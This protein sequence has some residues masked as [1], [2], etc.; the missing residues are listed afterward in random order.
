MA[1]TL[2]EGQ[3]HA[4]L[5]RFIAT[6]NLP[7]AYRKGKLVTPVML[8]K[9]SHDFI[10]EFI[11]SIEYGGKTTSAFWSTE[12]NEGD[13]E[14]RVAKCAVQ[15]WL[16]AKMNAGEKDDAVNFLA[17][18]VLDRVLEKEQAV[19]PYEHELRV[20]DAQAI[21]DARNASRER[22]RNAKISYEEQ[23]LIDEASAAMQAAHNMA[24]YEVAAAQAEYAAAQEGAAM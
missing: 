15:K 12:P 17:R 7:A 2:N 11:L 16:L 6:V 1:A 23:Q 5:M 8:R 21:R 20:A 24:I 14:V 13:N 4:D 9:K 18:L 10:M 19:T 22:A 3:V